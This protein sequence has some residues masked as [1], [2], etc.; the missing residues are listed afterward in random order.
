MAYSAKP[1]VSTMQGVGQAFGG[2]EE[3]LARRK[4]AAEM[5]ALNAKEKASGG[6]AIIAGLAPT[7]LSLAGKAA[8]TILGGPAGA[9]AG[10]AIGEGLGETISS[11]DTSESEQQQ[12]EQELENIKAAQEG[13]QPIQVQAKTSS[14]KALGKK[15]ASG[16]GG[17]A[18]LL[19][20]GGGQT[21]GVDTMSNMGGAA[22]GMSDIAGSMLA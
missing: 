7:V 3:S 8:G 5:V 21:V 1:E 20:K 2:G 13:R 18:G 4:A 17:I 9:A 11:L 10:S 14:G 22:E 19:P 16:I 12:A 6:G 15:L